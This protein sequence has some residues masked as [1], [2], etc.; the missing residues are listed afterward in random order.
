MNSSAKYH[1]SGVISRSAADSVAVRPELLH[2]LR[3]FP[4]SDVE[5]ERSLGLF[6]RGSLLA[7]FLAVFDIY[8]KIVHLP[9]WL[10]DVGTWRGQT[11]VQLENCRAIVEPLNFDRRIAAF[12]TFRRYVGFSKDDV[13]T[14]QHN[15]GTYA[16]EDEYETY[17]EDLLRLHEKSNAMGHN[18]G[19]HLVVRGDTRETLPEFFTSNRHALVCLAF[20]DLNSV[21]PSRDAVRRI[22]E[23]LVPGGYF[24]FWQLTQPSIPAEAVVVFEE[25]MSKH[26]T[27]LSRSKYYPG[28]CF[29]QKPSS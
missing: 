29:V 1:E 3:S 24:A 21:D 26:Q 15:N 11:A 18:H 4:G 5:L 17:L 2:R 6:L 14:A 25:L 12:D 19:K 20:L 8:E 13:P 9:G 23:R 22:W 28:L 7:R 27:V 16:V 10:L